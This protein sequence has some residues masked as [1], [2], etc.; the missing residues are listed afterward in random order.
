MFEYF[1][2]A[3]YKLVF[4]VTFNYNDAFADDWHSLF[5]PKIEGGWYS[6]F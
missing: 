1:Y 3:N 4:F 6:L 5:Y 2:E